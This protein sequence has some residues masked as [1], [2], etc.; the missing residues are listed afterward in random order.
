MSGTIPS[1]Y[2][3]FSSDDIP[4]ITSGAGDGVTITCGG[5]I[6][7]D[8]GYGG[9]NVTFGLS[10]GSMGIYH[11][12]FNGSSKVTNKSQLPGK[13]NA[14]NYKMS[15]SSAT[16]DTI[17]RYNKN[18]KNNERKTLAQLIA[19]LDADQYP[20][21]VKLLTKLQAAWNAFKNPTEEKEAK[22]K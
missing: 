22:T 16:G 20:N 21:H 13:V 8:D 2:W 15:S 3:Q 17:V 6:A 5:I 1:Y 7:E 9:Y 14:I 18:C 11:I 12:H 19:D 10:K 4:Q